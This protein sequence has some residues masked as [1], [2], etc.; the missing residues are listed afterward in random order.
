[1]RKSALS[2]LVVLVVSFLAFGQGAG[3]YFDLAAPAL[4]HLEFYR[5]GRLDSGGNGFV[6][7]EPR[8]LVTAYHVATDSGLNPVF[9]MIVRHFNERVGN[10]RVL[11][12]DDK[13]DVAFLEAPL[14]EGCLPL[15]KDVSAGERVRAIGSLLGIVPAVDY[16][17]RIFSSQLYFSQEGEVTKCCVNYSQLVVNEIGNRWN[18]VAHANFGSWRGQSGSA[19]VDESLNVRGVLVGGFGPN[20]TIFVP[21]QEIRNAL[22][23]WNR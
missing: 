7:C 5:H 16:D 12:H 19:I 13:T 10:M 15:G 2:I 22:K 23:R 1:M 21:V 14:T 11:Y 20:D 8:V 6:V 3:T 9:R 17:V 18:S 4:F